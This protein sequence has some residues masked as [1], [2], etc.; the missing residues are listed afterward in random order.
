MSVWHTGDNFAQIYHNKTEGSSKMGPADANDAAILSQLEILVAEFNRNH[1]ENMSI[2]VKS[3]IKLINGASNPSIID[4]KMLPQVTVVPEVQAQS[5][6]DHK[7]L[8]EGNEVSNSDWDNQSTNNNNNNNSWANNQKNNEADD[9]GND[10]NKSNGGNNN[11]NWSDSNNRNSR[12]DNNQSGRGG[13]NGGGQRPPREPK[14]GDWKCSKCNANNFAG[15][16]SC[17]RNNCG[18]SK[19]DAD[20]TSSNGNGGGYNNSKRSWDNNKSSDGNNSYNKKS[21]VAEPEDDWDNGAPA[22]TAAPAQKKVS[23]KDD[24]DW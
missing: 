16:T 20:S 23:P 7:A 21:R 17:Y 12:R 8:K 9:W 15:R 1:A 11:N 2:F 5:Y 13:F 19:D 22:S 18:A 6:R 24:D 3:M 14:P 10:S 4:F